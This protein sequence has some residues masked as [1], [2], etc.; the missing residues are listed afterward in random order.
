MS[1]RLEYSEVKSFIESQGYSLLSDTYKSISYNLEMICPKGHIFSMPLHRF[2]DAGARCPTCNNLNGFRNDKNSYEVVKDKFKSEG[3][4]LL[5]KEY[6]SNRQKLEVIC[7]QGHNWTAN[8]HAFCAGNRCKTCWSQRR[9]KDAKLSY[10]SVKKFIES[11]GYKLLTKN[12]TN[13]YQKL[14]L[15]CPNGHKW[16]VNWANFKHNDCRCAKCPCSQSKGELE[17]Y[18]FIKEYFPTATSGD[19]SIIPPLELDIVVPDKKIAIEYNGLYWH[20][21]KIEK[22]TMSHLTKLDLCNKIGYRLI[23]IFEDEWLNRKDIVR[24]ILLNILGCRKANRIYARKCEVKNISQESASAFC[25]INHLQGYVNAS[26]RLGAFFNNELVAV[27]TFSKPNLSRNIKNVDNMYEL[28][29]FCTKVGCSV[30][31]VASK[32]F[33]YFINNYSFNE[34]VSYSDRRWFTGGLYEKLG[35]SFIHISPP[36]YWYVRN[37]NIVRHHRFNFRKNILHTKLEV[38]D[39]KLTEHENMKNNGWARIWDCGTIKWVYSKNNS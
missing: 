24:D 7:P 12:Y 14:D 8:Y 4:T 25:S 26:I 19:R 10:T 6:T 36:S 39:E 31:G 33:N 9:G 30:I 37:N 17:V 38:F 2:K 28:S 15:V 32:L 18:E 13:I 22:D 27:M 23:T 16:S 35:F 1:K 5:T 3:Y 20:S 11:Q 34:I 29:R 21:D